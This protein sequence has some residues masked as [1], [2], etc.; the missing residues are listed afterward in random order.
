MKLDQD[1]KLETRYTRREGQVFATGVQAITRLLLAQTRADQVAGLKTAG[2]V[3]GYRGSPLG[4]LDKELWRAQTALEGA[5][6]RFHPGINEELAATAVMGSQQTGALAPSAWDG[7]FGLWYGKG[8]GLDRAG[9]ALKHANAFGSSRHGGVLVVAGDD[10]GA[11]S[12]SMGHQSEQLMASWMMPVLNPAGLRDYIDFG[13]YGY[14]LSRFAGCWVGF[15]AVSEVVE[16]GATI[17]V[18]APPRFT[19]PDFE[20]PPGGLH[21]R[22]PDPFGEIESRMHLRLAALAAFARANRLDRVVFGSPVT[23]L[24]IVTTG[25]AYFDV[26]EAL[27]DAGIDAPLAAKIGLGVYK[28]GLSWPIEREGAL[29]F[30]RGLRKIIVVEEKRAF[31]ETQLKELMYDLPAAARPQIIGKADETGA[32]LLSSVGELNPGDVLTALAPH[33]EELTEL[34]KMHARLAVLERRR[35]APPLAPQ[36]IR[37]PYFCSGCPHNTST[38]VPEGSM[39][40]AG[41][42]CSFMAVGMNRET[43]GLTQMGGEGVNWIGLQPFCQTGHV[44]QNLGDGTY[45]HSGL[46]AIRQAVAAG[47]NITYKI[48][49]NDAVAMTGGQPHDGKLSVPGITRQIH[50]EGVGKIIVV[51]DEPGKY[52]LHAGFAPGVRVAGRDALDE[53]QR[54]LR[55]TPGVTA[56]VYDQTCA[57]EK[58]RRRKRGTYPD[59]ARRVFIN[60]LVCEACGD[61][62]QASN[63]L[64]IVPKDTP[65]GRKRAIDQSSCNKDFSCIKGFCPSFVTIEGGRLRRVAT[66]EPPGDIPLP[67]G[68]AADKPV[69]ILVTGVGGTGVVT[70]G[71]I[72]TMAAH[73]EGKG[74]SVLDFT[75]FAQK[76]GAV[77]SYVRLAPGRDDLGAV[78]IP[79]ARADVLLGCDMVVAASPET[80][81]SLRAGVTRAVINSHEIPTADFVLDRDADLGAATLRRILDEALG[82]PGP[83]YIEAGVLAERLIGDAIATNM[84]LLGY[85]FQR[86]LIPLELEALMRAVELNG[87]AVAA[88]RR[89]FAWGRAAA[90]DPADVAR[91]AGL[92]EA[93]SQPETLDE[94]IERRAA[95]LADYQNAA[96]GARYRERLA[97]VRAAEQ[98]RTPG[99]EALARAVAQNYFKLLAYKDEYEV[100]RLYSDGSFARAL[101]EQFEGDFTVTYHLSPPLLAGL[102]AHSRRPKKYAFGPWMGWAFKLLARLKGLRGT[103][104]DPF[105]HSA[106]RRRERRLITDYEA[107]LEALLAALSPQTHALAVEIAAL[108]DDIR[109]FGPVKQDAIGR[110]KQ[111]R[112]ELLGRLHKSAP[113]PLAAE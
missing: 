60:D 22:W 62:S 47:V 57:A 50:D 98:A 16:S 8:P 112:A 105:G 81:R 46:L 17:E 56:L 28:I 5:H 69:N 54:E 15:K 78:R 85:G 75:G 111:A 61:C 41:I 45:F 103:P 25:K 13:L 52:P 99:R 113:Q 93:Q 44:F 21:Y 83:D 66:S 14:A 101:A 53:V 88:N 63:C 86:G 1:Y 18:T 91:L 97:R 42:G 84:L 33:L 24:G 49:Y 30:A 109:G 94:M 90:H 32:P 108:P 51:T 48:L 43:R 35:A 102:D 80:V 74:A 29:A 110:M 82:A 104:F 55:A 87:V 65:L 58:R 71:Q 31:I 12:S 96:Y 4:G 107:D 3:S 59:P 19:V 39:A 68:P 76:G 67:A 23:R 38:R 89:A 70:I 100:A 11:V 40:M 72:L 6:I 7:V 2:F 37:R 20:M 77:I 27:A 34:P 10:H 92:G 73:L 36:S 95:F 9:D 26:M 64:S 79:T 106:E